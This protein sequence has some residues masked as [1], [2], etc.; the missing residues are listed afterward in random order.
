MC[1]LWVV[2]RIVAAPKNG[3]PKIVD[4]STDRVGTVPYKY[5]IMQ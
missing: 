3:K 2:T 5:L 4:A 1:I